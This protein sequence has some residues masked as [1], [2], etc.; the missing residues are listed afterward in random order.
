M[1]TAPR[2]PTVTTT[3]LLRPERPG[4]G[5]RRWCIDTGRTCFTSIQSLAFSGREAFLCNLLSVDCLTGLPKSGC[6]RT[7]GQ[8]VHQRIDQQSHRTWDVPSQSDTFDLQVHAAVL[9]FVLNN[10]VNRPNEPGSGI[11]RREMFTR[12][13]IFVDPL[14]GCGLHNAVPAARI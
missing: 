7:Y 4:A 14:Q 8:M 3:G 5:A 12:S 1:S 2:Q 13:P 6:Q 9:L 11:G 10:A